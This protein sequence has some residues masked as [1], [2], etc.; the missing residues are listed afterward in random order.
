MQNIVLIAD[1]NISHLDAHFA[2]HDNVRLIKMAGRQITQAI[3]QYQPH[4]LFIRSVTAINPSL[5]NL[6]PIEFIASATL[7]LDH[8]DT[9]FL[10]AQNIHFAHAQGSSKH[11]V[12]QY[13]ITAILSLRP[14]YAYHSNHTQI[15]LGIIGLGNIGT[16]LTKYA[17]DLGWQVRGFDPFL[18]PSSIN[19]STLDQVLQS[20]IVS[21]HTPL[22]YDGAYPTYQLINRYTLAQMPKHTLL[23]N[24][25]RGKIIHDADLLTDIKRTKR[26]VVLDV[27][28]DEPTI[29][30]NLLDKLAIATPHI[31]GYT[32]DAKLRGTQMVYQAFCHHFGLKAQLQQDKLLPSNPYHW[33][34]L[35]K[36]PQQLANFYDIWADDR[37][38]RQYSTAT[39]VL[40]SVFDQLR[41]DY[42]LKR[43]WLFDV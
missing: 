8:V 43:E 10:Q 21:I 23:I 27:F 13:V 40:P 19:N 41:K 3:K 24:A 42:A 37:Q 28:A 9:A 7:G 32:F 18:A 14:S 16:T 20:D 33:Q 26:Q 29:A 34:Q 36:N 38:L 5:G 6:A 4:A 2:V 39:G 35:Q 1:E 12:A 11:S 22:T 17:H 31:A 25:A 30:A 15:T